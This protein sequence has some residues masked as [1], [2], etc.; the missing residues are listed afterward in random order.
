MSNSN[1]AT[2]EPKP[3]STQ[4]SGDLNHQS[5]IVRL[6]SL[7]NMLELAG[8]VIIVSS[9]LNTI[10]REI[11]EGYTVSH[12]LSE[13]VKDL[14][15]TSN[16]ISSDLHNLVS[17]VR[18]VDMGD[19]F[20]RF[21]RLAR[22]TSRRLGKAIRFEVIGEDICIDKKTSEKIYDPIAHQ[23]RNAISHGIEDK[24]TRTKLGKD[25][26][27]TVIIEVRK[28]E[29]NTVIDVIDDGGGIN[30]DAIRRTAAKMGLADEQALAS[31]KDESLCEYLYVPGFSTTE[32]TS[33]T[34]GRGVGMDVVRD[35]MNELNGETKISTEPNKGTTFSFILQNITA[36]N[37]SD[38]LMVTAGPMTFAFPITSVVAS[39]A[40]STSEVTTTKGKHR[41]I[42][43]L[44]NI[45]PLFDLL[46]IF[47]EPG[48][49]VQNEQISVIVV[50]YK[51]KRAAFIVSDFLNP[52]KIVISEFDENMAVPGLVG[53]A[54]LS[55][56]K[57]G[58]V[59]DIAGLFDVTFGSDTI[60]DV[61]K[62]TSA[63][64][65]EDD[66]LL[67]DKET[68]DN[69]T[70]PKAAISTQQPEED[71]EDD[72]IDQPDSAFLKEVESMLTRLNRELLIL[73]EKRDSETS[74][75]IFRLMHSIKGNLTM[76][77][78]EQ[79]ASI[80]HKIETILEQTI[81]GVLEL[82]ENVFDVLFDGSVYLEDVVKSL[83]QGQNP[84]A[85]PG[86]LLEGIEKFDQIEEKTERT[87]SVD[88][89]SAQAVLDTTGE[90]Y[91]SSRRRDGALLQQ[92]RIEFDSSDQPR[93]L[94][95]YLI[96]R[97]IQ[98]VADVLG[99]FPAMTDIESGLCDSG[100][101]VLIAPRDTKADMVDKLG[102]N[103]KQY[104]GVTRFDAATFA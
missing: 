88:L 17:D 66:F 50:E 42:V 3:K 39:Q 65:T 16:R 44:G 32:K 81:R 8:Q 19:L 10:S 60:I 87:D 80:T 34:S 55:G 7:D 52:Q 43:Y 69:D 83:L 49:K 5:M 56:R 53:T 26:V 14:A 15:I 31:M 96:L 41:S 58:L 67:D 94:L 99:S 28:T 63:Q 97:R 100:L 27:G 48:L 21:R 77:G 40:F 104:Y 29:T 82:D 33:T 4:S 35:V 30:L 59:V 89:N 76:Y 36:V 79:P 74:D 78:A 102:D 46:E 68:S 23:I 84:A 9:N 64:T 6:A 90:F 1:T 11:Q 93:F 38:A 2:I 47:G 20:A 25:P 57:M 37:I 22:D 54:I 86:K 72:N 51:H 24:E 91:L 61:K 13:D 95:A 62:V 73:E 18:T 101:V 70:S 75:G 103:L 92:C 71:Y 85:V 45:L 12:L 98:R